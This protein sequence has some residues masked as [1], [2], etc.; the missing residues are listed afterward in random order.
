MPDKSTYVNSDAHYIDRDKAHHQFFVS[1]DNTSFE[2][3]SLLDKIKE[4][5][6]YKQMMEDPS[7]FNDSF[8]GGPLGNQSVQSYKLGHGVLGN[9]EN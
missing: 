6:T 2:N 9:L 5:R 7:M 4:K 8:R 1:Y 3:R